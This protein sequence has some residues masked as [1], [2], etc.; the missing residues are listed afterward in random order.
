[1]CR[2]GIRPL[3]EAGISQQSRG[4]ALQCA[5]R[6]LGFGMMKTNLTTWFR[7]IAAGWLLAG[8]VLA[9]GCVVRERVAY[10]S[11]PAGE[12]YYDYDYYPDCNVYFY[13]AAG[14]YYWNVSGRWVSGRQLPR[15]IVIRESAR[16][17]VHSPSREPWRHH[18]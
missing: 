17:P 12:V 1:M 14:V 11:G 8:L 18:R 4:A 5:R 6:V 16:Q 9:T 2:G 7:P 15:T 3:Q 10:R 13:P